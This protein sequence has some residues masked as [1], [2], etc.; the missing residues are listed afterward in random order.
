MVGSRTVYIT[1]IDRRVDGS[2]SQ[3]HVEM[4][5]FRAIMSPEDV[6][7]I[8]ERDHNAVPNI[9]ELMMAPADSDGAMDEHL[10]IIDSERGGFVVALVVPLMECLTRTEAEEVARDIGSV[11]DV[12]TA[13]TKHGNTITIGGMGKALRRMGVDLGDQ[14]RVLVIRD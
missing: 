9:T 4:D 7:E 5:G 10:S 14:V 3:V 13:I 6:V 8:W 11:A 1:A 12:N 2:I